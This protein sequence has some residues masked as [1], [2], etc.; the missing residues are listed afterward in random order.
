MMARR[1][2]NSSRRCASNI[3]AAPTNGPVAGPDLRAISLTRMATA[4]S[5][6][7]A[8]YACCHSSCRHRRKSVDQ[9]RTVPDFE[10]FTALAVTVGEQCL[11]YRNR[12]VVIGFVQNLDR[13][14]MAVAN[15]VASHEV[16]PASGRLRPLRLRRVF[17]DTRGVPPN[18]R[19]LHPI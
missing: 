14:D 7:R 3:T 5:S 4:L 6:L 19:R 10:A 9:S 2:V 17:A 12:I 13:A 11:R 8:A 15:E 18:V 16:S 1:L